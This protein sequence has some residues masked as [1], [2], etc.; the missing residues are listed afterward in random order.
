MYRFRY[1]VLGVHKEANIEPSLTAV[2][3]L[4][5]VCVQGAALRGKLANP[6]K[7]SPLYYPQGFSSHAVGG[8]HQFLCD[9]DDYHEHV[10][11][12]YTLQCHTKADAS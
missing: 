6:V 1:I 2:P 8:W 7:H 11:L 3:E 12:D 9:K 5:R 10:V 4:W